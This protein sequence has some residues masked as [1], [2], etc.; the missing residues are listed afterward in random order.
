MSAAAS[1]DPGIRTDTGAPK[2]Q[3]AL[4]LAA[5]LVTVVLWASAFIGI[6]GAGPHYDPGA[7]AL[8]RM[9]VGTVPGVEQQ[10]VAV[11]FR[12]PAKRLLQ[13]SSQPLGV[14]TRARLLDEVRDDLGRQVCRHPFPRGGLQA[15]VLAHEPRRDAQQPRP[16]VLHRDA[17]RRSKATRN[18]SAI[19]SSAAWS[20]RRCAA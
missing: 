3:G 19:T 5:A 13:P 8:L 14:D 7:L 1:G 2:K 9:A 4:V 20:P 16:G 15:H 11:S 6:R 10:S 12:E 18:V 17:E